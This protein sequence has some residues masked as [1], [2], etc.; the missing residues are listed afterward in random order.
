MLA[1]QRKIRRNITLGAWVKSSKENKKM[2]TKI[3][4]LAMLLCATTIGSLI[5]SCEG[6]IQ[7]ATETTMALREKKYSTIES[8]RKYIE[9]TTWIYTKPCDMCIKWEFKNGKVY[10]Y[11]SFPFG[12]SWGDCKEY[13]YQF[14]ERKYGITG[15][16][17]YIAV[18]FYDDNGYALRQLAPENGAFQWFFSD[19]LTYMKPVGLV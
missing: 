10:E 15:E 17:I 16:K 1:S 8:T 6:K 11:T 19:V 12:G 3:K 13:S 18:M 4:S 5:T 7:T 14:E 9:N 2:Q